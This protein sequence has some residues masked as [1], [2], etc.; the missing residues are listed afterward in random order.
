MWY[1]IGWSVFSVFF[2]LYMGFQVV[3][4]G[5]VPRRGAFIFASNHASYL[6]PAILGTAIFRSLNYM[7]RSDLFDGKFLGWALPRINTFPV[8]RGKGDLGAIRQALGI[9]NRGLPLVIFPEGTRSE[10]NGLQQAKPGIGFIAAR[11]KVPVVPAYIEG[12]FE[13]L[14][15]SSSKIMRHPLKVTIG[16]PISFGVNSSGGSGRDAYQ[17]IADEIMGAI[18][19]LKEESSRVA[20]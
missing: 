20:G 4:R 18:A 3:G 5:N 2:R 10:D 1:F 7:A 15:S 11:S 14:S 16:R 13:A 6:D 8:S 9:L 19:K 12:S 17:K